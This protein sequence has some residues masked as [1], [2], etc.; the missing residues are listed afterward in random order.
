MRLFS[1]TGHVQ[2]GH[3]QGPGGQ[4]RTPRRHTGVCTAGAPRCPHVQHD[5][6]TP[7]GHTG[8]RKS[9]IWLGIQTDDALG[10]GGLEDG[11]GQR[12]LQSS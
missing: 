7:R 5:R 3:A 1:S 9:W 6:S 4:G 10:L 11:L 12:L 8:V 2:I